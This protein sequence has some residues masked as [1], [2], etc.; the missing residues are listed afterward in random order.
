MGQWISGYPTKPGLY[1]VEW[2]NAGGL[3]VYVVVRDKGELWAYDCK[4]AT[5]HN[6]PTLL[7]EWSIKRHFE[8][9][10]TPRDEYNSEMY[11]ESFDLERNRY[12]DHN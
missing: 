2:T 11:S 9:P 6:D 4:F 7:S 12:E 3:A 5:S 10:R 8:L 1:V